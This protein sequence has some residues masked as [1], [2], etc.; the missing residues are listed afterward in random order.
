MVDWVLFVYTLNKLYCLWIDKLY[1]NIVIVYFILYLNS[2]FATIRDFY[3]VIIYFLKKFYD[4][5]FEILKIILAR[6]IFIKFNS[7]F[8]VF[9]CLFCYFFLLLA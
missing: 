5:C 1:R 3:F 6:D 2:Y 9:G 4:R 8:Y 7:F